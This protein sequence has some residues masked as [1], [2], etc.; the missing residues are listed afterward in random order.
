M[1]AI[2]GESILEEALRMAAE[3]KKESEERMKLVTKGL[4]MYNVEVA[5]MKRE[6]L[7]R[8]HSAVSERLWLASIDISEKYLLL[9]PIQERFNFL[10]QAKNQAIAKIKANKLHGR[11]EGRVPLNA[12]AK[13]MWS[14]YAKLHASEVKHVT[15]YQTAR[16]LYLYLLPYVQAHGAELARENAKGVVIKSEHDSEKLDQAEPGPIS[17]ASEVAFVEVKPAVETIGNAGTQGAETNK[18]A[19]V[20]R[21]KGKEFRSFINLFINKKDAENVLRTLIENKI[22]TDQHVWIGSSQYKSEIFV[23]AG[24]LK[25][26]EYFIFCLQTE[27]ARAIVSFFNVK[28]DITNYGKFENKHLERYYKEIMPSR[29]K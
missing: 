29:C 20:G 21:P 13:T 1:S 15:D 24:V 25:Q 5:I 11:F 3:S 9:T 10:L 19:L 23:L 6:D 2:E 4:R 12:T 27:L 28:V 17:H 14:L 26:K 22:I 7:K 8:A 16:E 18:A